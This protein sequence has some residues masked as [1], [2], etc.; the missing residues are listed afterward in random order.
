MTFGWTV[1]EVE[2]RCVIQSGIFMGGW[3]VRIQV[4]SVSLIRL[5]H[6]KP[7]HWSHF[8]MAKHRLYYLYV[9]VRLSVEPHTVKRTIRM[10]PQEGTVYDLTS[11][12]RFDGKPRRNPLVY[13]CI[14]IRWSYIGTIK[15]D[16]H[17]P[18]SFFCR[19]APCVLRF[20]VYGWRFSYCYVG[21]VNYFYR[22]RNC[23]SSLSP[24]TVP[25]TSEPFPNQSNDSTH[26]YYRR[27]L[28]STMHWTQRYTCWYSC[29][30]T[31]QYSYIVLL[32]GVHFHHFR[33]HWSTPSSHVLGQQQR[34]FQRMET[35]LWRINITSP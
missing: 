22:L 20:C 9:R 12:V 1:E 21:S 7:H 33:Y 29:E 14:S 23:P 10:E 26:S 17:S 4:L 3:I 28:G 8:W 11:Q 27:P 5:S 19:S 2:E 25:A 34:R 13:H 6:S 15:R 18:P 32:S 35:L 31:I 30:W 24:P 16:D